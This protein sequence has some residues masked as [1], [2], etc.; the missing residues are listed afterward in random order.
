MDVRPPGGVFDTEIIMPRLQLT[1][2][3]RPLTQG[4]KVTE[5]FD[6]LD[7]SHSVNVRVKTGENGCLTMSGFT[8]YRRLEADAIFRS[9]R[10]PTIYLT[11]GAGV[12]WK[13][14]IEDLTVAGSGLKWTAY[15]Q[16]RYFDDRLYTELWST[17]SLVSFDEMPSGGVYPVDDYSKSSYNPTKWRMDTADRV[18]IAPVS[19]EAFAT[20]GNEDNGGMSFWVPHQ[21]SRGIVKVS[22]DYDVELMTN[23]KAE[24]VSY[25][26][27]YTNENVE[28]TVTTSGSGST[29]VTFTGKKGIVFRVYNDS[30]IKQT[31]SGETGDDYAIWSDIRIWTLNDTSVTKADIIES[32]IN[33]VDAANDG[34]IK[35][36]TILVDADTTDLV[37]AIY[38]DERPADILRDLAA[39]GD[40]ASPPE[41]WE[42]GIWNDFLFFR[43]QGSDGR[44]WYA[45]LT[46]LEMSRTL[47]AIANRIYATYREVGGRR[48]LRTDD[49]DDTESQNKYN[50][51]REDYVRTNLTDL[52][53]AERERDTLLDDKADPDL[54]AAGIEIVRLSS[55]HGGRVPFWL[56]RA[57]DTIVF[58]DTSPRAGMV[59]DIP[60]SMRISKTDYDVDKNKL[61]V[62]PGILSPGLASLISQGVPFD[63]GPGRWMSGSRRLII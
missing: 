2:E 37:E 24:I 36:N 40:D 59:A 4:S 57:G 42:I 49:A 61:K 45:D 43:E 52:T 63:K 56:V 55:S 32:L 33:Y 11:A 9:A 34:R 50:L 26:E 58:R 23:W 28:W 19:G 47:A 22:F 54:R 21:S 30:G 46:E 60:I 48:V 10:T 29:S 14:R 12:V 18:Y 1:V 62:E 8:P 7:W 38:L 31:Y 3:G 17:A 5:G 41:Q 44:T 25:N 27:S 15:G 20:G 53:E 35:Q 39:I 51:I 6:H 13:G 16:Y